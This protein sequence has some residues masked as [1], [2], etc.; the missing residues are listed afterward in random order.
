MP[1]THSDGTICPEGTQRLPARFSP[2]CNEFKSHT[3]ACY[4]DIRYEWWPRKKSW[5]IVIAETAGGGGMAISYCPHC[6][7]KL[8]GRTKSGRLMED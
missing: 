8:N 2:C 3:L 4:F 7:S 1:N 5:F 6:G